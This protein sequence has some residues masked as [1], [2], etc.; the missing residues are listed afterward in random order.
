MYHKGAI[1][2]QPGLSHLSGSRLINHVW[3][4]MGEQPPFGWGLKHLWHRAKLSAVSWNH[5]W[6]CYMS[7]THFEGST[8][9]RIDVLHLSLKFDEMKLSQR[10]WMP[11]LKRL[12]SVWKN[13][14]R[15]GYRGGGKDIEDIWTKWVW[16]TS[17]DVSQ[18][19]TVTNW[20]WP[21]A[22]CS[23][24]HCGN[25]CPILV[26]TGVTTNHF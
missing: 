18:W 1:S 26:K 12:L 21:S 8:L 23:S 20:Q 16:I 10:L 9:D 11:R 6:K 24:L 17:L 2:C 5:I 3:L 13:I 19:W 7:R 22:L 14:Y 25:R 15:W 4:H